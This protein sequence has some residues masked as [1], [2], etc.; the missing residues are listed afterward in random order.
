[1]TKWRTGGGGR[2]QGAVNCV[3][4]EGREAG[5][6]VGMVHRDVLGVAVHSEQPKP[7]TAK[8]MV[9]K[10]CSA[11]CMYEANISYGACIIH[12]ACFATVLPLYAGL[13]GGAVIF[14]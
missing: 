8:R 5:R 13:C 3:D 14:C 9:A 10:C 4:G 7:H 6:I 1:L 2:G 11:S 12:A